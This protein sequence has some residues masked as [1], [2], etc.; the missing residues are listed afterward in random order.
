MNQLD[1]KFTKKI[2]RSLYNENSAYSWLLPKIFKL[3]D[4]VIS[5]MNRYNKK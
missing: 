5:D 1:V 2:P 3:L 4:E